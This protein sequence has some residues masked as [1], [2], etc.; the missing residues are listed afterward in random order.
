[1]NADNSSDLFEIK[2]SEEGIKYIR[3]FATVA[4]FLVF[5]GALVS[6]LIFIVAIT[7]IMIGNPDSS[8]LDFFQIFYFESYSYFNLLHGIL[9]LIQLFSYWKL[10]NLIENGINNKDEIIFNRS[11]KALFINAVW[12]VVTLSTS[13][14]MAALDTFFF[15]KYYI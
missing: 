5:I 15:F 14:L 9:F 1:M 8:D 4:K 2:L 12:G 13:L 11:F 6:L 10:K 7:R 3:K